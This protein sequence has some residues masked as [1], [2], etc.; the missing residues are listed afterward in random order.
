MMN[1]QT[2]RRTLAVAATTVLLFATASDR[3]VQAQ[4]QGHSLTG[5]WFITVP[6][7]LSG[8][9]TYHQDGT[10]TGTVTTTFGAPPQPPGPLTTNSADHGIWRQVGGGFEGVVFRIL[11]DSVTGDPVAM[12]RIRTAFQFDRGRDRTS[13]TFLVDQWFCPTAFSC[14]DP[15]AVPPDVA[16]NAPPPPF[17]TFAQ[18]RV[19]L[20]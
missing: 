9:Y 20:P 7:G 11:F 19:R 18:T 16:G 2:A 5:T 15:N 13:G 1:R 12:I 3:L 6:S 4:T 17:N 8:Y 10:M 14:P